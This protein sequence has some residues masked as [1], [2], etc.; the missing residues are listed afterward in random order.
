M[1]ELTFKSPGVST[2][3]I[4]LSGPTQTLPQGVPA[5][6]IGTAETGPA[7]VPVTF[8]TYQDF[9]ATFGPTDGEMEVGYVSDGNE[10]PA[11]GVRGGGPGGCANQ[12]R[13][14][15][16]GDLHPLESCEQ[17]IIPEGHTI[18]SYSCGGGGYGDPNERDVNLVVDDL[19]D[20]WISEQTVT[21]VYGVILNDDG[22]VDINATDKVRQ[23]NLKK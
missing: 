19:N 13:R 14:D 18:V 4:D 1:A 16:N 9:V 5:G 21:D 6:I 3:E 12:F 7:F 8:A 20:R 17:A 10:T 15:P 2:R 22:S 23:H 11:E